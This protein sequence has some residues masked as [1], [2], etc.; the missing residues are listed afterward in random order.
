MLKPQATELGYNVEYCGPWNKNEIVIHKKIIEHQKPQSSSRPFQV[1]APVL[2]FVVSRKNNGIKSHS[3]L[4]SK[5]KQK[6]PLKLKIDRKNCCWIYNWHV[7]IYYL[8]WHF[9]RHSW[10]HASHASHASH[11][12]SHGVWGST[13]RSSTGSGSWTGSSCVRRPFSVSGAVDGCRGQDL[14]SLNLLLVNPVKTSADIPCTKA[15][16]RNNLE[17]FL[18]ATWLH[19][20]TDTHIQTYIWWSI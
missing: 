19:D 4:V 17:M 16:R 18:K 6:Q 3:L 10:L 1:H 5:K 9:F 14:K 15:D 13:H 8:A 11:S 7:E 20:V 2:F 12:P